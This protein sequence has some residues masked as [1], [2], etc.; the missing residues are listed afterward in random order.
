MS[1]ENGIQIE[2]RDVTMAYGSFVVMRE[3]NFSVQRGEILVIMGPSGCGKSTLLRHMIGLMEPAQGS[4]F[5]QGRNFSEASDE[6]R[7]AI[8]RRFG[9]MYQ[10][11][12][13]WSS[14]TLGENVAMPM[15]EFTSLDARTIAQIVSFKLA[16]VGLKGFE[17]FYPSQLSGG[18]R[19]RAALARAISLD[20]EV[21]F[22]DEPSAGL[23][24]VSAKRLDDLIL[25]LRDGM[26]AT[27]V[28]VT[29]E[30]P[31]IFAIA[32]R[33][34]YLDVEARTPTALGD[35]REMRGNPPNANVAAFLN[36][37]AEESADQPRPSRSSA[38]PA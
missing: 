21:V 28:M 23:D 18:M 1:E 38:N 26:G 35:P 19:K 11:G 37:G 10:N 36:R 30:L 27:I 4:V 25:R 13:L 6:D 2:V 15:E 34:L 17:D 7:K 14:M 5:F 9:V 22:F 33:A 3:I 12:A 31:S 32:D 20:P 8:L 16:L 29:H 24:P